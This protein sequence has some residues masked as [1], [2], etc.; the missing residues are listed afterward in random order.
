[1]VGFEILKNISEMPK[2]AIGAR[3]HHERYDGRGYPD[4]LS[5]KNIPEEARIIAVAD[6]YDAM[7]SRR[8]YH[9][10]FSQEYIV[11][12]LQKGRG[13]QFDPTF[14][15]IMLTIIKEDKVYSL[16]ENMDKNQVREK[17]EYSIESSDKK[18]VFLTMLEAYGFQPALGM[19][20]CM[21]DIDFYAEM[22]EEFIRNADE[23]ITKLR[24]YGG[25]HNVNNY[26]IIVHALKSSAKSIG[27]ETLSDHAKALEEAAKRQDTDYIRKTHEPLMEELRDTVSGI[28][29]TLECFKS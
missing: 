27:C 5:G 9:E 3:W 28:H 8:S 13:T 20:Y 14:A 19:Q 15:D 26:R 12:E 23:R 11:S 22:L 4:H 24:Q 10:I 17:Y 25:N 29:T 6:A 18:H 1:M 7:S 2:L 16:K 21:N